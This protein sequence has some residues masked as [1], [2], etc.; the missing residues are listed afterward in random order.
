[1]SDNRTQW[2]K[3]PEDENWTRVE[4]IWNPDDEIP[5]GAIRSAVGARAIDILG[6]EIQIG[7]QIAVALTVSRSANMRVGTVTAINPMMEDHY[8]GDWIEGKW[9]SHRE[10][11]PTG[12]VTIRCSWDVATWDRGVKDSSIQAGLPKYLKLT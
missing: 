4:K 1:M 7:D 10:K 11:R 6:R 8:E 9:V 2:W 5:E 3:M 12:A